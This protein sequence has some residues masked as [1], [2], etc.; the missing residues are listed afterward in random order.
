MCIG[1][2]ISYIFYN[3]IPSKGGLGLHAHLT[4]RHAGRGR[5]TFPCQWRDQRCCYRVVK[6]MMWLLLRSNW[7][8]EHIQ[9]GSRSHAASDVAVWK[10]VWNKSCWAA[11]L[12]LLIPNY[13]YDFWDQFFVMKCKLHVTGKKKEEEKQKVKWS[14]MCSSWPGSVLLQLLQ[15]RWLQ[16]LSPSTGPTEAAV[17]QSRITTKSQHLPHWVIIRFHLTVQELS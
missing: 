3:N 17:S 14:M 8:W 13:D 2:K 10:K 12:C 16:I 11:G 7:G 9:Y 5:S 4:H 15:E 6:L 1:R